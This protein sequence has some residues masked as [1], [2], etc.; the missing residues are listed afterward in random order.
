MQTMPHLL[1]GGYVSQFLFR[2][3]PQIASISCTRWPTL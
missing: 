3:S 2:P 1:F